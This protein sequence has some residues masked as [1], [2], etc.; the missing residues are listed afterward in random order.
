MWT[1]IKQRQ[2]AIYAGRRIGRRRRARRVRQASL[3]TSIWNTHVRNV[4]PSSTDVEQIQV[5][6]EKKYRPV[7]ALPQPRIV[8]IEMEVDLNPSERGY[9][10]R[11]RY[12]LPIAPTG[13][14]NGSS[15]SS[16]APGERAELQDAELAERDEDFQVYQF[17]P[18]TP[19]LPGETRTLTFA[20]TDST[21]GFRAGDDNTPIV[22]NGSF[23]HSAALAPNIGIQPLI[24][25][26]STARRKEL[27]LEPLPPL[28]HRDDPVQLRRNFISRD[29]DFVRFAITVST[30]ADQ[31][32]LAP[33]DL[34]REWT[35]GDRQVLPLSS[36]QAGAEFLVGGVRPLYGGARHLERR[37]A[38]RLS[39]PQACHQRAAHDRRHEA[40]PGLLLRR[41][42]VRSRI[43]SFAIAEFPRYQGFAQSFPTLVPFSEAMGFIWTCASPAFDYVWY[44]TAH[45]TAHQWWGHQ[46]VGA[47]VEGAQFLSE[48]L[49]EYSALMVTEHRYGPHRMRPFL[50]QSLDTYLRGRQRIS[51][52]RPLARHTSISRTLS[53][54]RRARS[55]FYALK[56]VIGEDVLNRVLAKLL[57][58]HGF[59]SDPYPTTL[60][61]L[62][63][64][65]AEAG[66]AHEQLI[67]DLIEKITL[68]D[69]RVT[70]SEATER[71]DGKWQ[72]RVEVRAKKLYSAGNGEE[73]EDAARSVDRH[74]P[75]RRRSRCPRVQRQGCDRARE[76]ADQKRRPDRRVCGR[77]QASLCRSRSLSQADL[78]QHQQQCEEL[79]SQGRIVMSLNISW[80]VLGLA[81]F[82]TVAMPQDANAESAASRELLAAAERGDGV[83]LQRL[84]AAGVPLD[85]VDAAGR[86]PLLIAVE[87]NHGGAAALLIAAGA[88]INAQA[89]NADTPWLLAGA[90]GRADML[91]LM[92]PKGPDFSIRNRF[93]GNAL[94]PACERGHVEAVRVLLTSAIDVNHVNNL[95]WTCLLEIVIL[96]DGG[97]RHVEVTRLVLAAGANPNI[98]D[99]DGVSPLAHARRKGQR[100]IARLIEAAGG[101]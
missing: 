92:I 10:S 95:G 61:F 7:E 69:L 73:T 25:L 49:A 5:D 27:G 85:P 56:D 12:V 45:E 86:T 37:R 68:W 70:G 81:A 6:Y 40:G 1:R 58:E 41:I 84:I 71:P 75:V 96:G 66:P 59:K 54:T 16:C 30:S 76:A 67:V 19:F 98:A 48:S 36:G 89:A 20:A 101:R 97:P 62:A 22:Y 88:N 100:E 72:V 78:A 80:L 31:M 4:F 65:R 82:M 47:A 87:R 38:R 26:R 51:D 33:G 46:I 43:D 24:Y 11:G 34:E 52:E 91:R 94:I 9:R 50:K 14:S 17:R 42:S 32:A 63:L 79:G 18:R 55:R 99:K 2:L 39:H 53:T 83:E 15:S 74:R 13:R 23:A 93:G 28:A 35:E 64:L 90:L 8:D 44:V 21:P 57:R 60:D 3:A 29:T 77:P